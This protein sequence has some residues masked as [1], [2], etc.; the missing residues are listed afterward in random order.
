MDTIDLNDKEKSLVF[1]LYSE[2]KI[3]R[4]K[5]I[6]IW[7]DVQKYVAIT[8]E[9]NSEFEECRQPSEQK[10]I[11][12][13]DPTA[14]S[15][16][17][18]AGDYLAGILWGQNAVTLEPSEYVKNQ[19]QG[20]DLSD[21]YKNATKKFLQQMDSTDAGF[22]SIL[23]AY[24]YDQFS[25]G[26]SGIGVFKSKEYENEQSECCLTF[27]P[28]G[29]WNS[30]ADEGSNNKID[31]VF[32]VYNWRLNRIVE[33]FCYI[34]G[35]FSKEK[36]EQLPDDM[37]EAVK[38][39][40]I[41]R[42]F[43]LVC[44]IMPNPNFILNK[45]GK[46]GTRFK[47]YWFAEN[48]QKTIF[49][50][51]YFAKMPIS[52]CRAIRVNNQ[53]YGESSGTLAISAIKML[54]Y[55]KET[56]VDNIE[57]QTDPALGIISGALAAGNVIDRSAGAVNNLNPKAMNGQNA[58]FPIAPTGDIAAVV[59]ALIPEL[60][61][62]IVNIFKIDQL[63][64]FNNQTNMTATESSFRMAIRGKSINGLLTQEKTEC[65][66]PVCHRAISIMEDCK[67]FG[68]T[69]SDILALPEETD[70][71]KAYKKKLLKENDFIPQ[72]IEEAMKNNKI[73]YELK[74]NGE[75]EKLSNA[76]VYEAIGRFLQYMSAILQIQPN[77]VHAI[78]A[79]EFLKLLKSVSNLVNDKLIISE[80][81]YNN[82]L[83]TMKKEAQAQARLQAMLA[84]S[85]AMKNGASASR[86]AAQ[87]QALTNTQ[88]NTGDYNNASIF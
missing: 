40:K 65:I 83:Q 46:N 63:L 35:E 76:E 2:L 67:L 15:C 62:N 4:N 73:W 18:Q 27:K 50:V 31:I 51:E 28:F 1:D 61:K 87:A 16:V 22:Q 80:T 77:L 55:I 78:N 84:Q 79:Y 52:I 19:A 29:V 5:Y 82:L 81:E 12:I 30:C 10:D 88:D 39:K 14:P 70:I 56:T 37:K 32:T 49:K 57:K 58:I 20:A 74:F 72:V 48:S 33:E 86:D 34:D 36:F 53:V 47:G 59:N 43:K 85:Q 7:K 17:Y 41:N 11:F 8:N 44:G 38:N 69:Y 13:N 64:D 68:K 66:E 25:Y 54:N 75:I 45:R 26:T 23:R 3:E 24:C 60:Q 42:K 6:P 21:F 9:V 71:E